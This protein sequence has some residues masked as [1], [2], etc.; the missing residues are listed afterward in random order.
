MYIK[1]SLCKSYIRW[2][3][4]SFEE[5]GSADNYQVCIFSS[6]FFLLLCSWA[7]CLPAGTKS[8]ISFYWFNFFN[9]FIELFNEKGTSFD[10]NR[11]LSSGIQTQYSTDRNFIS[12]GRSIN[13]VCLCEC[14]SSNCYEPGW[15]YNSALPQRYGR[16]VQTTGFTESVINGFSFVGGSSNCYCKCNR[17]R[18]WQ[19]NGRGN[20]Q[21]YWPSTVVSPTVPYY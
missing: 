13:G 11:A 5:N 4:A 15:N 9:G 14:Y 1:C 10:W 6:I 18:G 12:V 17:R 20:H 3:Y 7:K 8:I 21:P 19:G 16:Q 2:F